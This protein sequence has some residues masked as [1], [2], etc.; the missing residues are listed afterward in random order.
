MT[1]RKL[2]IISQGNKPISSSDVLER[3]VLQYCSIKNTSS[4]R[5]G[6]KGRKEDKEAVQ[7]AYFCHHQKVERK[8]MPHDHEHSGKRVARQGLPPDRH[9]IVARS[10][11]AQPDRRPF[12]D[13]PDVGRARAQNEYGHHRVL[14]DRLACVSQ[15]VSAQSLWQTG[16]WSAYDPR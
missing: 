12:G 10:D 15:L 16:Q 1:H 5:D 7:M 13:L 14:A 6:K 9:G 11:P 2:I 8:D 3:A 4:L